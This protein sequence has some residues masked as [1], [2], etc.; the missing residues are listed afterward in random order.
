MT[1]KTEIMQLKVRLLGISP[2]I[3]RGLLVDPSTSLQELHG[4]LQVALGG[5]GFHLYQFDIRGSMYGS[6]EL[7]ILDPNDTLASFEF[8]INDRFAYNYDMGD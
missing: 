6:F 8:R 4:M 3:W 2:M 5:E 7:G 1:A